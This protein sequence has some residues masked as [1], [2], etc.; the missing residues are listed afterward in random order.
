MLID[1]FDALVCGYMHV[2]CG[3]FGSVGCCFVVAVPM[4]INLVRVWIG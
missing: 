2:R 1:G 3:R 4:G